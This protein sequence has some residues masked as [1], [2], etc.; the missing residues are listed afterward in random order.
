MGRPPL[1]P[2]RSVAVEAAPYSSGAIKWHSPA[3]MGPIRFAFCLPRCSLA[4]ALLAGGSFLA[5]G[6]TAAVPTIPATFAPPQRAL[7]RVELE[8]ADSPAAR[9]LGLMFRRFLPRKRG[10][11]FAFDSDAQRS[12]WMKDTYIPLDMIFVGS[13]CRVVD[14]IDKAPPHSTSAQTSRL[15]ARYVIELA[16]GSAK[17]FGIRP[18]TKV[19]FALGCSSPAASD[20]P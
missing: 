19:T 20:E 1:R 18:G 4:L 15:P 17:A 13:H 16:G 5:R 12:F 3:L 8:V 11:L 14:V 6:A 7:V 2:D 10:M 9:A